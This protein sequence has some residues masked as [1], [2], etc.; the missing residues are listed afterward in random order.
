[1]LKRKLELEANGEIIESINGQLT[2][3]FD[4]PAHFDMD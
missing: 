1:M 3:I 4:T 2:C